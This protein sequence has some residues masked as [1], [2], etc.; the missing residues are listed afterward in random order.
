MS[1]KDWHRYSIEFCGGTHVDKAG[2]SAHRGGHWP[3]AWQA[4]RTAVRVEEPLEG[5]EY[6]APSPK[7][8]ILIKQAQAELTTS[9]ISKY[10]FQGHSKSSLVA[11]EC[12]TDVAKVEEGVDAARMYLERLKV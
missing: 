7:K 1:N 4:R 3:R 2:C 5:L 10:D 9:A 12:R 11:S 6:M 8:E